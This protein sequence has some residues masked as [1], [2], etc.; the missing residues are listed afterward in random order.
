MEIWRV[1]VRKHT[2]SR[3]PVPADWDSLGGRG[4]LAQIL[5]DEVPATCEPLGRR[6][7]L[8]FA[9]GLLVGHML[10]SCDRISVGGKSPL[11]GGIKESNAGGSTGLLMTQLGIK[12]LILED[13]PAQP[14]WQVLHLSAEGAR[15]DP[16]EDNAGEYA[17]GFSLA[18]LGVYETARRLL[19]RYGEKVAISLI[20]P[21]GEMQLAAAGIQ[22]LDKDRVPSR[23][24]ARGGLG[25]VMGSKGIKAV[26]FD[27]AGGARGVGKP[28]VAHLEAFRAAQKVF[29]Q[30]LLNHPQTAVYRDYG[31]AS[32][33]RMCNTLG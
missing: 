1:N 15:F 19:E 16:A 9:P 8:V 20:G 29:N 22:N 30:S 4:L 24:N 25:A 33:V 11:T 7:K 14:G 31:T 21:G 23:I 5:V 10:S 28:P 26:V 27:A 12:A 32:L 2:L 13:Q 6:N 17:G 18:G 3:E